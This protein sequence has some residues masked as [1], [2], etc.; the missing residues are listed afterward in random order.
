MSS[1]VAYQSSLVYEPKF[2]FGGGERERGVAGSRPM[3]AAVHR[4]P[5]KLWRSNSIF[6]L[7]IYLWDVAEWL[8]RLTANAEVTT[9]LGSNKASSDTVESEE[10]ADEAVLNNAH[11]KNPKKSPPLHP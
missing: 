5:N 8:E 11:L 9:V 1:I 3:S 10:A 2:F 6:N 7:W 4:S